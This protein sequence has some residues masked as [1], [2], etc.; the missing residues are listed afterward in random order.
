MQST[1]VEGKIENI[2]KA[3]EDGALDYEVLGARLRACK[4]FR[5]RV[6]VTFKIILGADKV[7]VGGGT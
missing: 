1:E 2:V 7:G 5:D 6:D 3:V 4:V